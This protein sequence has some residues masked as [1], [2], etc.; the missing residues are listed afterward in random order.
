VGLSFPDPLDAP[1][2]VETAEVVEDLLD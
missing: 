2:E 1:G